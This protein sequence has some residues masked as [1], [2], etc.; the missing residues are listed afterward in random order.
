MKKHIE[1]KIRLERAIEKKRT[2]DPYTRETV[3]FTIPMHYFY[4]CMGQE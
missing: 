2:I 3:I 1:K 4:L